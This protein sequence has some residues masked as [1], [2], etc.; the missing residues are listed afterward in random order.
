MEDQSESQNSRDYSPTP[1]FVGVAS[2]NDAEH[3][4]S[5]SVTV[6]ED[7]RTTGEEVAP[8]LESNFE[9]SAPDSPVIAGVQRK[10][11]Q[12]SSKGDDV[13]RIIA[14]NSQPESENIRRNL[15]MLSE[16]ERLSYNLLTDDVVNLISAEGFTLGKRSIQ[17]RCASGALDAVW[18]DLNSEWRISE[19]SGREF[20]GE[21]IKAKERK[22][23]RPSATPVPEKEK[24]ETEP[25]T[26]SRKPDIKDEQGEGTM[27]GM[28]REEVR[29]LMI[30]NSAKSQMLTTLDEDRKQLMKMLS[31]KSEQV[32]RLEEQVKML[33]DGK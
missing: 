6:R 19:S 31:E 11:S 26:E 17:K 1:P 22:G 24:I 8:N 4:S 2:A 32:G 3:P 30:S 27:W 14:E 10:D 23:S 29:D 20:V 9:V 21:W 12:E 16:L 15:S 28:N 25:K 33:S 13:S 7:S 5:S 18:D